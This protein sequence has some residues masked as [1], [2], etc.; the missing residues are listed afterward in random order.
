MGGGSTNNPGDYRTYAYEVPYAE[1]D[2]RKFLQLQAQPAFE[3][4][5]GNRHRDERHKQVAKQGIRVNEP[6]V[7]RDEPDR[8][9]EENG[10][11]AE[12]P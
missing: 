8:Q 9:K 7:T 1:T 11:N 4:D 3:E 12:L 6:A 2:I 10:R 5:D